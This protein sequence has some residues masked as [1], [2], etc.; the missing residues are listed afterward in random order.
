[1]FSGSIVAL[2]TP[3]L[4]TGEIDI[5]AWKRLL[6]WHRLYSDGIVILGTTGESSTLTESERVEL[7]KLSVEVLAGEKPVI[8][9]TGTNCTRTS[10]ELTQQALA[11]GADAALLITPYYN[12]P[13]QA[14]LVAHYQAVAD[15][16]EIPQILYNCPSRT[17]CSLSIETISQLSQHPRIVAMKETAGDLD[18]HKAIVDTGL[19]LLSGNDEDTLSMM[20]CGAKGVISVVA[21]VVPEQLQRLCAWQNAGN[22]EAANA[23]FVQ[24]LPLFEALFCETNPIPVKFAM[25]SLGLIQSG[26]RLPLTRLSQA[27]QSLLE[28]LLS[29]EEFSCASLP[30]S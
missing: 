7:I 22:T 6:S 18:R 24:M 30:R 16:V 17:G 13:M 4:P 5:A 8:V 10:I 1:M 28:S 27:H 21:N 23:L 20:H 29:R 15:A 26:I 2:V 9:G 3:M 25:E 11:L 14:G 12:R 19:I